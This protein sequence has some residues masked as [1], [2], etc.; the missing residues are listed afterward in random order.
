MSLFAAN[1]TSE[2][3]NSDQIKT[4][5]KNSGGKKTIDIYWIAD[6]GGETL[7]TLVISQF[8]KTCVT[9]SWYKSV[10][11]GYLVRIPNYNN[12]GHLTM[13]SLGHIVVVRKS[14]E[15]L[16]CEFI[17]KHLDQSVIKEKED[18]ASQ[19]RLVHG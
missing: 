3:I 4:V 11:I 7:G 16:V 13:M 6:D 10:W 18:S 2:N 19:L 5:F 1:D 12:F 17:W 9:L 15:E 8:N 14:K